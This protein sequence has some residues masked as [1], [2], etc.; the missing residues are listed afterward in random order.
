MALSNAFHEAVNEGNVRLVRIM[1]KDSLLLDP[2]FSS[3]SEMERAAANLAGLYDPHDGKQFTED[4]SKWNDDYMNK[5]MVEVVLNFSHER[6]DHLKDVVHYLRPVPKKVPAPA[7]ED[8]PR[9]EYNN[10]PDANYQE[11]K[12]RAQANGDYRGAKIAAGTVVGAIAGGVVASVAGV[13]I[14]AGV[15]AGTVVGGVTTTLIV[16]GGK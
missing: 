14:V 9:Y 3:F 15:A 13:S 1:M 2:T 5:L 16:N 12:R 4:S 10:S 8:K 7:H 6:V 11:E